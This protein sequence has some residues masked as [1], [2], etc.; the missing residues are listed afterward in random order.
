MHR[1]HEAAEARA[2]RPQQA[3]RAQGGCGD[4]SP[5]DD[6]ETKQH[7]Q[8]GD[9]VEGGVGRGGQDGDKAGADPLHPLGAA[10]ILVSVRILGADLL[11]DLHPVALLGVKIPSRAVGF[12]SD[13]LDVLP[14]QA[15]WRG[16]AQGHISCA[17][18]LSAEPSSAAQPVAVEQRLHRR[19]ASA[20]CGR[21][22]VVACAWIAGRCT[23]RRVRRTAGPMASWTTLRV[24]T[25]ALSAM[26]AD[27]TGHAASAVTA[28]STSSAQPAVV[29]AADIWAWR[30]RHSR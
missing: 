19:V 23:V 17:V 18:S 13:R 7:K 25:S 8:R 27:W 26:F 5:P 20:N 6:E 9:D 24:A 2:G 15:T 16:R 1:V 12:D 11:G 3:H 10:K 28:T 22:F 4:N 21:P 14:A 29:S 30:D